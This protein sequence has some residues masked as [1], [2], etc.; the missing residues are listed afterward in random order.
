MIVPEPALLVITERRRA[1]LPLEEIA[2]AAFAGGC[3]WLSLREK[4]MDPA[5]RLALLRRLV[6]LGRDWDAAVIVH[7]DVDAALVARAAGVHLPGGISPAAARQRLGPAALIGCSAHHP[8]EIAP[9][10]EAGADYATFSPIFPSA[11]KPGYGPPLGIDG[12]TAA[13]AA[14]PL[15]LIAL[16]G[17]DIANARACRHAGAVGI[18][19]MGG[20]MAAAD[21]G[22]VVTGLIAAL[23]EP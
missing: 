21:P 11:G 18:A 9:L 20:V 1:R 5:E 2:A 13:A 6:A 7:A 17:I 3:R 15:P 16:G 4:D 23:R 12:L 19:V 22:A 14:S 10:A 8:A